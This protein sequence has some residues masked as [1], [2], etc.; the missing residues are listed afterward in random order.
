MKNIAIYEIGIDD[1]G[2]WIGELKIISSHLHQTEKIKN[3]I[4]NDLRNIKRT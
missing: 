3:A 1:F 4:I 2:N